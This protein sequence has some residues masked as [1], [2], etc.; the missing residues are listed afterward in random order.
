MQKILIIF[1]SEEGQTEKVAEF[2]ANRLRKHNHEVDVYKGNRLPKTFSINSYN[3]IIVA[4]SVHKLKYQKYIVEFASKY[5]AALDSVPSA[6][7]SVSMAEA[8]GGFQQEWFDNFIDDTG[9]KPKKFASFAGALMY[10]K[11]NFI[12]RSLIKKFAE[13]GGLN[14]DTSRNHEYTDWEAVARFA[15]EFGNSL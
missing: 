15:D 3:A 12:V 8:Q 13:K 10:R 7:V 9:W 4:G 6:F 5:H 11:Y 2:I 14:T 1:G